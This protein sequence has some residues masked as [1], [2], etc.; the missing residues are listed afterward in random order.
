MKYVKIKSIKACT[1]EPVY[2][3]VVQNNHNF[4]A[5][6]LLVHNCGYRGT[7]KFVFNKT[8]GFYSIKYKV[9]DRIG[10]LLILPY[11]EIELVEVNEL[12]DSERGHK[13]FG[14]TGK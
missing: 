2:H 13:G 6:N 7:I 1:S 5:N 12:N 14:S 8:K 9:G 11:P 10:Q 3:M 4:F